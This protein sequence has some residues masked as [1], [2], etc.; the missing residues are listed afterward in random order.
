MILILK[1]SL[2]IH[3]DVQREKPK[4]NREK[5][6]ENQFRNNWRPK[7][8]ISGYFREFLIIFFLSIC[9]LASP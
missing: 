7:K 2:Q 3:F 6:A 8:S 9:T 1:H 5:S 4:K